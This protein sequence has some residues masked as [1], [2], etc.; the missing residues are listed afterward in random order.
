MR[1]RQDRRRALQVASPHARARSGRRFFSHET[2]WQAW[3]L[4]RSIPPEEQPNAAARQTKDAEQRQ[5]S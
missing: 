2:E 5:Q 3:A 1:Y 4:T